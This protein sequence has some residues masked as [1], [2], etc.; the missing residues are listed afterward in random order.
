MIEGAADNRM[1]L[2]DRN[3]KVSLFPSLWCGTRGAS[4][5]CA[6]VTS[7]LLNEC[8]VLGALVTVQGLAQSCLQKW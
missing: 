5:A 6:N 4:R 7:A 8:F 2:L 3:A 1:I